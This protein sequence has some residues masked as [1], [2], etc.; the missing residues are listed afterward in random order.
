MDIRNARRWAE[1]GAKRYVGAL[2]VVLAAFLVRSL[3]HPVLDHS[4]PGIFFACAAIIVEFVWGLGPAIMAMVISIPIFDFFFVPPF[5]DIAELDRRDALIVTGFLMITPLAVALIERLRRAQ[6]RAE[7]IAEVAQTRYEMLL[8]AENERMLLSD[9]VQLGNALMTYLTKHLDTIFYL[10][11]PVTHYE[12]IDEHFRRATGVAPE[13]VKREG[14]RALLHPEDALRLAGLFVVDGE[15]PHHGAHNLRMRTRDGDYE[16]F[17][18]ELQ[19]FRAHVGTYV[20][21]RL[22][23]GPAVRPVT[24]LHT[25]TPAANARDVSE[26]P[27][28][29]GGV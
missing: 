19:Y 9:S 4:M 27:V 21:L 15:R 17:H 2:M 12:F 28:V 18:C 11:N 13:V 24:P 20:I 23:A 29:S 3:L 6:Y 10:A 1:P 14:L 7:L 26:T 22:H 5:R 16:M 25:L 8:R